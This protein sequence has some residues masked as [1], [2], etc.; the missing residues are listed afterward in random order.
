MP[1]RD[2]SDRHRR[3]ELESLEDRWVLS[4]GISVVGISPPPVIVRLESVPAFFTAPAT[5][6]AVNSAPPSQ[7]YT[8][9]AG[10]PSGFH[11]DLEPGGVPPLFLSFHDSQQPSP[12]DGP[13]GVPALAGAWG[14]FAYSPSLASPT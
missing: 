13:R 7:V 3:L 2:P 10:R 4:G 6:D 9:W 14:G 11:H 8:L 12:L 1:K 5:L